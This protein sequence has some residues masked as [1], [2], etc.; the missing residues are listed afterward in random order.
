MSI[1]T[2]NIKSTYTYFLEKHGWEHSHD[3]FLPLLQFPTVLTVDN[4]NFSLC[5]LMFTWS[6]PPFQDFLCL[7]FNLATSVMW[8]IL[9][10]WRINIHHAWLY[11]RNGFYW[12]WINE[13][14][15]RKDKVCNY[16]KQRRNIINTGFPI[17]FDEGL[18]RTVNRFEGHSRCFVLNFP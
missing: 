16:T 15:W 1:Q 12:N 18:R 13:V 5:S 7:E 11:K 9:V 8:R 10:N 14:N 2:S 3:Y 17:H 4:L 6:Q